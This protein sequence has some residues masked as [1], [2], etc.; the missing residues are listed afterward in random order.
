MRPEAPQSILGAAGGNPVLSCH[1]ARQWRLAYW[2]RLD[3]FL[4]VQNQG[5]RIMFGWKRDDTY[6]GVTRQNPKKRFSQ[7]EQDEDSDVGKYIRENN[8]SYQDMVIHGTDKTGAEARAWENEKRPER[9]MGLNKGKAGQGIADG[10]SGYT[11]YEIGPKPSLTK[12]LKRIFGI[13]SV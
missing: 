1:H 8:L 12:R 4:T 5:E 13:G 10:K 7:H 6:F 9:G 11:L 3:A 2:K